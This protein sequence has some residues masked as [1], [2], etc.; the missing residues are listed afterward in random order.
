IED[1]EDKLHLGSDQVKD[2]IEEVFGI[3]CKLQ[4]FG[5]DKES[6]ENA[7]KM[8]FLKNYGKNAPDNRLPGHDNRL[9]GLNNRLSVC[10]N[11]LSQTGLQKCEN[12]GSSN[13]LPR[14]IID[15]QTLCNRLSSL[16]NRLSAGQ[17]ASKT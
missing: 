16:D 12:L 10:H 3:V 5:N 1:F 15:Y 7:K 8:K 17:R 13:R 4:M 9:Y 11:R 14:L 2:V 6:L